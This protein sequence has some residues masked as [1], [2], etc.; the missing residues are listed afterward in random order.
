MPWA[1][2]GAA[3]IAH[4]ALLF[5]DFSDPD[6]FLR[7]DRA[8]LRF[9]KVESVL[10]TSSLADFIHYISTHGLFGDYIIHAALFAVGGK[11]ATI[12]VQ[13][14]LV[15]LSAAATFRLCEALSLSRRACTVGMALFLLLP[16][17]VAFPHLLSS[18]AVHL[19]L[20]TISTW[21]TV[22]AWQRGSVK[23]LVVA[24]V[25]LALAT[26][27]RPVT[28][29]WPVVVG[30]ALA[31]LWRPS[32]GL[33]F[34]A[35]A[36]LPILLWMTFL[37]RTTGDFGLGESNASLG[38]NLYQRV[39]F[40]SLTLPEDARAQVEASYLNQIDRGTLGIG[41]YLSFVAR[42]PV[43]FAAHFGRDS[44]AFFVKSGIEKVTIDYL[45][46]G[47][48]SDLK[49]DEGGGW[50]RRLQRDGLLSAAHFLWEQLGFL[51]IVSAVGAVCMVLWLVAAAVGSLRLFR[52][53]R[54]LTPLQAFEAVLLVLLPI[55]VFGV[56]T[57]VD[58]MQ[59]RLRAPAEFALVVLAVYGASAYW[60]QV[61]LKRARETAAGFGPAN[62][63]GSARPI[64]RR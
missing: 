55:Y 53:R 2:L 17:S 4:V 41:E 12:C 43:P 9:Y 37:W 40:I 6:A 52:Q 64:R 11:L 42:Y 44:A 13:V 27:V 57:V 50:R 31:V 3:A 35:A 62:S 23:V 1:V 26:L 16:H 28:L 34:V 15:L 61:K 21:L 59:S 22:S 45:A 63:T 51:L 18:E 8:T 48:F 32:K 14:A 5:Y 7:A 56:S 10:D 20:L 36:F 60:Q 38:R 46:G 25:L 58:V 29:L 49:E 33:W 30:I 19:P 47:S 39:R 24:G 54:R